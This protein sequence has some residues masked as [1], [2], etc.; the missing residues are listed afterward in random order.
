MPLFFSTKQ[1][2]AL[3]AM[4]VQEACNADGVPYFG[5]TALQKTMYFLKVL[6]VPMDYRF[7]IHHYG[8]FCNAIL[9]DTEMLIVDDV[10]VDSAPKSRYSNYA[11]GPNVNELLEKHTEVL[12]QYR[13]TM[14]EVVAVLAPMSPEK[15]ELLATLHFAFAA[16]TASGN[17]GPW[18]ERVLH[19]F[20]EFKRDKFSPEDVSNGYDALVKA[21]LATP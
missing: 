11:P 6:G 16:E 1:D 18:K 12:I 19:R 15:L 2:D 17:Q 10:I 7:D 13:E 4:V 3:L 8:P 21:G 5:R 9:T 20:Q 14:R